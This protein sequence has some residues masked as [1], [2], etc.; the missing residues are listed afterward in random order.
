M[1][2]D[3]ST[4]R[5]PTLQHALLQKENNNNSLRETTIYLF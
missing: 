5:G 4:Q 2:K 1:Q 3:L